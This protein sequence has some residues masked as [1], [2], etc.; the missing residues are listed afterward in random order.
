MSVSKS[1]VLTAR[2]SLRGG[3]NNPVLK[4][5]STTSLNGKLYRSMKSMLSTDQNALTPEI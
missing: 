1:A 5:N 2:Q 3:V 4:Q